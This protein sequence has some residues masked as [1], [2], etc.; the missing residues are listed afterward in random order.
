MT[1]TNRNQ[2]LNSLPNS[3]D[4]ICW[5][6][7]PH[8]NYAGDNKVTLKLN[9][10][11]SDSADISLVNSII[12]LLIIVPFYNGRAYYKIINEFNI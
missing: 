3:D 6:N 8:E 1:E 12:G 11:I 2:L 10:L 5:V 7:S 9:N 4:K